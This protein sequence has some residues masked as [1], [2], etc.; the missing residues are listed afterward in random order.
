MKLP[1]T[2]N[3][4]RIRPILEIVLSPLSLMALIILYWLYYLLEKMAERL[5]RVTKLRQ[6]IWKAAKVLDSPA[7]NPSISRI[8]IIELALKNMASK[9][10]RTRVT[11]FGMTIGIAGIVFLVS[12]GY[13][14]QELVVKRVARLEEMRQVDV[15]V[16]PGSNLSITEDSLRE[17]A[18]M[19]DVQTVAPMIALVAR[20]S[21][22]NSATDLVAYGVTRDYLEQSAIQPVRGEIFTNNSIVVDTGDKKEPEQ[23]DGNVNAAREAL[24]TL[25]AGTWY[26]VRENPNPNAPLLG[27]TRSLGNEYPAEMVTGEEYLVDTELSNAWVRAEVPLWNE[28]GGVY[29]PVRADSGRQVYRYGYIT[30]TNL[31]ATALGSDRT[32][33]SQSGSK[34]VKLPDTISQDVVVN[35][36]TLQVL[37]MEPD[38]AVGQIFEVSFVVTGDLLT[39][40]DTKIQSFPVSYRIIGVTPDDRSPVM[41]VPFADMRLLGVDRFSQVKVTVSAENRLQRVRDQIETLGY[42][43]SS[44]VDTVVRINSI[45]GTARTMLLVVGLVA[46]I[47]ASLGMFNTLTVSLLERT[48]EVGLMKAMGLKSSEIRELFLA[49][50]MIMGSAGG[51]LGLLGGY[52][53]A[54]V[55]EVILSIYTLYKGVGYISIASMPLGFAILIL[56]LSFGVGLLTGFY[57]ARRA[58]KISALNALRYE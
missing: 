21:F 25:E 56:V 32:S 47:I 8:D 38:S 5:P 58:T 49:E 36:A 26:R 41:Y 10:V 55:L 11:I 57:P 51:I 48:R 2:A 20:A 16:P 13:G 52:L 1:A 12:I 27:Y 54:K 42:N 23:E 53:S 50:S 40:S 30:E 7:K 35:R 19:G 29:E 14:L 17:F 31:T 4:R 33:L 43:T 45:F 46:L 44:V 22:Q 6:G 15:T 3:R 34:Q 28:N 37:G 24:I 39:E 18:Q 9:K